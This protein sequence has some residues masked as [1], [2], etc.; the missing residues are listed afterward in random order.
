MPGEKGSRRETRD[1]HEQRLGAENWK[2]LRDWETRHRWSPNRLRHNAATSL[3]EEFG[4]E[5]AQTVLGHQIGSRITEIYAERNIR[6]AQD[7]IHRVG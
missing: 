7:A 6:K 3:R 4:L 1:E 5:I 2:K